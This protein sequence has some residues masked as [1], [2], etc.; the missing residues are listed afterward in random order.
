MD[1]KE[2]NM[3]PQN[4]PLWCK[5][6]FELKRQLK[7]ENSENVLCQK[8]DSNSAFAGDRLL[9]GEQPRRN[10]QTNFSPFVPSHV[11]TFPVWQARL[12]PSFPTPLYT[13]PVL[14]WRHCIN[15]SP[16]PPL[17]VTFVELCMLWTT[18]LN[19]LVF[20]G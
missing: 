1:M 15:R 10:L 17:W 4:M 2:N 13:P 9:A 14:P 16:L 18:L 6:Y 8:A 7:A 5:S 12:L 19:K 11:P 3:L 20:F